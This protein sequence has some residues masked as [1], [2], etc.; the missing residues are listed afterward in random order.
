MGDE[1]ETT[2]EEVE[3]L[4]PHFQWNWRKI[5]KIIKW[6]GKQLTPNIS[7]ALGC[8]G[9]PGLVVERCYNPRWSRQNLYGADV[10]IKSLVDGVEES[11]SLWHCSPEAISKQEAEKRA[12]EIRTTHDFD[13]SVQYGY[14]VEE[15]KRWCQDWIGRGVLY[16]VLHDQEGYVVRSTQAF[17]KVEAEKEVASLQSDWIVKRGEITNPRIVDMLT[18]PTPIKSFSIQHGDTQ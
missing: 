2:M 10:A 13:L 16:Y 3:R 6:R 14:P 11:C 8:R 9:H 15:V 1:A 7:Y 5:K 4:N 12:E 17:T 18:Y